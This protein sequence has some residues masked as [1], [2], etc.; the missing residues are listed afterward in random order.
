M[1]TI[2][3]RV[4][5]VAASA[6]PT[7]AACTFPELHFIPVDAGADVIV[8]PDVMDP[9]DT[10]P[11]AADDAPDVTDDVTDDA[12]PFA[13]GGLDGDAASDGPARDAPSDGPTDASTDGPKIVYLPDG[14]CTCPNGYLYPEN[15]S[16]GLL[17]LGLACT[18]G[19]GFTGAPGCNQTGQFAICSI[20]TVCSGFPQDGVIQTCK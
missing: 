5:L 10:S 15:F 13:D 7:A 6:I 12:L 8:P 17:G 4:L 3:R 20:G 14:G 2:W 1:V 18:Q 9:G 16:C 19:R 11:D